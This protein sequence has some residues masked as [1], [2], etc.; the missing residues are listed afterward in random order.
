MSKIVSAGVLASAVLLGGCVTANISPQPEVFDRGGETEIVAASVD[1]QILRMLTINLAHGRGDGFHQALQ[2]RKTAIE[3]L[4]AIEALIRREQ[5]DVVAL[6]EAD[7]PSAWSGGFDHVDYL[8]RAAKFDWGVHTA[9]A[10]G[11]GLA[12][13]T[14]IISKLPMHDHDAHTFEPARAS[15]PKG[16]SLATIDWPQTGMTIDVV[17]VHLEPLRTAIRKRQAMEVIS[18]LSD[19]K[20]PLVLMGDLNTEWNHEDGVLRDLVEKLELTAYVPD[21]EDAITYPRLGRRLDWILISREFEFVKL[22]ILVDEISDHRAVVAELRKTAEPTNHVAS[23][24]DR[25]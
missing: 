19:R 23:G 20:R 6:Q 7:S 10:E 17:S 25:P 15:L 9:H 13:G 5:P 24:S 12:Y 14:A 22:K 21:H 18:F 4:D 8:A 2:R 11:A 3:N 1:S 16:F